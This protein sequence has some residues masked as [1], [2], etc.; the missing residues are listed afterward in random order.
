MLELKK[1]VILYRQHGLAEPFP[2]SVPREIYLPNKG[3]TPQTTASELWEEIQHLLVDVIA[4]HSAND[5]VNCLITQM[6]TVWSFV[7][8]KY[9]HSVSFMIN[10][11]AC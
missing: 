7:N 6:D 2:V 5:I 11:Y 8:Q 1:N 4:R 3:D 10:D 9:D